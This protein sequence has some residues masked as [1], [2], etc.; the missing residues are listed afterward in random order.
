MRVWRGFGLQ[1]FSALVGLDWLFDL[2]FVVVVFVVVVVG[3]LM[4]E[5]VLRV[6][7]TSLGERRLL[8]G[9]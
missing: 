4:C 7:V 1:R 6:R 8:E 5:L 9:L 2:C 3:M